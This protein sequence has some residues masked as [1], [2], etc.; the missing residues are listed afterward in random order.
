MVGPQS[1]VTTINENQVSGIVLQG[2]R[3][4]PINQAGRAMETF[5]APLDDQ[6]PRKRPHH[7]LFTKKNNKSRPYTT[8]WY[9]DDL[10]PCNSTQYAY[11][12]PTLCPLC[13]YKVTTNPQMSTCI[14]K[15]SMLLVFQIHKMH[16]LHKGVSFGSDQNFW[17]REYHYGR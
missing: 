13:T 12:R 7:Q 8:L 4:F 14:L 17:L 3:D 2:S 9:G 6:N 15:K 1:P 5:S 16:Y 10:S 11:A